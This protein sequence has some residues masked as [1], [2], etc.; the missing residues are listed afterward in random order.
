MTGFETVTD[1][2]IRL[3]LP[4]RH[5]YARIARIA[6]AALAL[7]LGF[8]Y[9]EVE[10]LRLAVDEALILLL[11]A[12]RAD[13]RVEVLYGTEPGL[14]EFRAVVDPGDGAPTPP[15]GARDR[16]AALVGEL[17]DDWAIDEAGRSVT[18]AKRHTG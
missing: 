2:R 4:A 1:E 16:F 3:S 12:D 14:L 17:V 5:E 18:L 13:G 7:R 15:D 8:D 10:D 9:R 11:G 6:V